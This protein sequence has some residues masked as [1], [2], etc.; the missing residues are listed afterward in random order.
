MTLRSLFGSLLS[1]CITQ[2]AVAE[3]HTT[4]KCKQFGH[5]EFQVQVTST[6]IPPVDI[7]WFLNGL[8]ERVA[9]G[10]RFKSGETMQVGWML[11]KLQAASNG[12]LKIMEPD[13]KSVPIKF[14]DSID[15]TVKQ[16]RSQKDTVESFTPPQSLSFPAVQQSVVV[17][18]NYKT[19]QQFLF[20]RFDQKELDSGWWLSDLND[21]KGSQDPKNFANISLYQLA[22]DRPDLIKF[23]AL[24]PGV[25]VVVDG[26]LIGVLKE[27]NELPQ[28]PG[29]FISELNRTRK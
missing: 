15:S 9:A 25:Q 7:A 11:T 4:T 20:S 10:E 26:G 6:A 28:V 12:A 23:L 3:T 5:P 1:L 13:M 29:S 8:E 19:T 16:L 17:H 21:D 2:A 14:V 24:P 22:I 18:R 27:G